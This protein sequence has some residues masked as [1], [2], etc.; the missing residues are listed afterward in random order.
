MSRY[1]LAIDQGTTST[2]AMLF[3]PDAKPVVTAQQ[4]FP[5]HF[6]R[7][8][9]VEHTP[10]DLWQ[11]TLDS[12]RQVMAEQQCRADEII[13]IGISNQRE[14]TLLWDRVTGEPVANAIVWQDRRTAGLCQQW[15]D[16]GWLDS[17][18][19]RTG[20]LLDPYFSATKLRW[21]LDS[22][23]GARRRAEAG[24]LLFGT[25][26]TWLIW[27]LTDGRVHATDATN[28]S[29]TLLFN[30]HTQE[31][32][33]VL[34]DLFGIPV[35]LLPDVRDSADDFGETT[36]GLLG[37]SIPIAGVAG[38][39]QAALFGQACFEP[40]MCKSTYGTGCFMVMNTG[41]TPL[42]SGNQLLTTVAYRLNGVV[43]YG[44]EGSIFMAGAT[45]QWL[46]DG[47]KLIRNAGESVAMARRAGTEHNVY[48]VPAF[49]GLGAPHWDPR[50]RGAI[51]GLTRDTGIHEVV[52]AGLQAVGYQTRD[53]LEAMQADGVAKLTSLRVDGGMVV[54]DWL[55]QFLADILQLEVERPIVTET[56]ALG[57]AMLAAL[58][59]GLYGSLEE[60]SGTWQR[61]AHF[62][63]GMKEQEA[64]R[65]YKGWL[66]AVAGIR[67]I[68]T[69]A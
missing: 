62:E 36:P 49:T 40:G 7:D 65:L 41:S 20:L 61:A 12:C 53:L 3:T 34:L 23:P 18:R 50:A 38:D 29:R 11:T 32:D 13:A 56:T 51:V 46:R 57:V 22:V 48:L 31:W 6:P 25:V 9:W 17:V 37:S 54:N 66:R 5:Q 28:A 39:Q 8:G 67:Y 1:L 19:D 59:S 16:E 45:M 42:A 47:I 63:P 69:S 14:T 26:D 60:L 30:I 27:N 52:A 44:L 15:R 33:P 64:D 4:E 35:T 10:A 43:T 58:Q 68:A 24:E 21:L 2:R 55:V